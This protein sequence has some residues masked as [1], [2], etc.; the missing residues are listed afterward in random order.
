MNDFLTATRERV[1]YCGVFFLSFAHSFASRVY[2]NGKK[3]MR[4]TRTRFNKE[5]NGRDS[6]REAERR[7]EEEKRQTIIQQLFSFQFQLC[8][9]HIMYLHFKSLNNKQ[10]FHDGKKYHRTEQDIV[11]AVEIYVWMHKCVLWMQQKWVQR[12]DLFESERLFSA[13]D[14]FRD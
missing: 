3:L 1:L 13:L 4:D 5:R 11:V 10:T 14:G 7:R 9:F 8:R 12:R 6:E 2:F